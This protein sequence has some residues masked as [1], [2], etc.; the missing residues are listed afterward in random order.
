MD[1]DVE[2]LRS[3]PLSLFLLLCITCDSGE[4][5]VQTELRSRVR[6]VNLFSV[7]FLSPPT[8][9]SSLC[10]DTSTS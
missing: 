6:S 9:T 1:N 4:R 2:L 7:F 5:L 8:H 10:K 3:N